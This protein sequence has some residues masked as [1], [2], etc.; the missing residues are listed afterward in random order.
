MSQPPK[1]DPALLGTTSSAPTNTLH[2]WPLIWH[3]HIMAPFMSCKRSCTKLLPVLPKLNLVHSSS[4]HK[5]HALSAP[6]W[7][8]LATHYQQPCSKL[9]TVLHAASS[10]TPSNK[11]APR[12]LTCI[13]I[14]SAI[15]LAKDNSTFVGTW[16]FQIMP[17]IFQHI[18]PPNIINPC[19][20]HLHP[21][22]ANCNYYAALLW[23]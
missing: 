20:S 4:K 9:M 3:H 18:T 5:P 16:A 7:K 23:H 19:I 12:Q 1:V 6:P 22:H 17:I 13:F 10:M 15:I 2:P 11:N 21:P 14:G 8:N